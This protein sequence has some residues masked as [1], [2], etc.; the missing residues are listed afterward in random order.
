LSW[1]EW[2]ELA[3]SAPIFFQIS[4]GP[5]P[6]GLNEAGDWWLE[7]LTHSAPLEPYEPGQ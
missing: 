7:L 5:A 6:E 3:Q 4:E 1:T 2:G